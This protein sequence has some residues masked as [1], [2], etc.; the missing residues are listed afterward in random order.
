MACTDWLV[1]GLVEM[2]RRDI[3]SGVRRDAEGKLLLIERPV[4][5]AELLRIAFDPLR[6]YGAS[7]AIVAEHAL[8]SLA[9]LA[10]LS[11]PEHY[12]ALLQE[13]KLTQAAALMALQAADDQ[14]RVQEAF[15]AVC[16]QLAPPARGNQACP[17]RSE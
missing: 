12:A 1:D 15:A 11:R 4:D 6:S 13:A 8:R 9:R 16:N 7:S 5:F 3:P 17:V 2:G 10:E 14:R